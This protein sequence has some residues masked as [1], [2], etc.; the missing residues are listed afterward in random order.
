MAEIELSSVLKLI[1]VTAVAF[2]V[3]RL[4]K[5]H[6]FTLKK[7]FEEMVFCGQKYL[8]LNR[9]E[10]PFCTR[11]TAL[12]KHVKQKHFGVVCEEKEPV[13]VLLPVEEFLRLKAIEEHLDDCEIAK[14][15]E[16]RLANRKKGDP[17]PMMDFE[18]FREGI[19]EQAKDDAM[20]HPKV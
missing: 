17:H 4:S 3:Y 2:W 9:E 20:T 7:G 8:Q 6:E 19:Y 5:T 1:L 15:I 13:I 18:H 11:I 16:E 12:L 14:I 10:M